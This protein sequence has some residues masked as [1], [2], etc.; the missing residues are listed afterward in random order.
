MPYIQK[1]LQEI[2]Q[3]EFLT[4]LIVLEILC[5]SKKITFGHVKTYLKKQLQRQQKAMTSDQQEF[6]R[7]MGNITLKKKE[8]YEL[9]TQCRKFQ[10]NKCANCDG[11]LSLPSVHFMCSH[12]Y[13]QHCLPD[14]ERECQLCSDMALRA[15]ERKNE[16]KNQSMNHETFYKELNADR[17]DAIAKYFGRG[18][19]SGN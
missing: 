8:I 12:S 19:F 14:N 10:F 7:N 16:F 13:H 18:L 2:E 17:F 4:P 5:K 6:E 11:K 9:K 15:L 3:K 1:I